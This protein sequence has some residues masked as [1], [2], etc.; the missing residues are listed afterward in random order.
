M[1]NKD[2]F[3]IEL[4]RYVLRANNKEERKLNK[5]KREG[6]KE[7]RQVHKLL[8]KRKIRFRRE[9][10]YIE[11]KMIPYIGRMKWMPWS[12]RRFLNM[13]QEK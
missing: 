11:D 9:I 7:C 8:Q 5:Q 1:I 3:M 13:W 12:Y 10:K 6:I 2:E 4:D